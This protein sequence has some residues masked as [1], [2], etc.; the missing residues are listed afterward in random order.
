M[1]KKIIDFYND[2][3]G[4]IV[5][6]L[7]K[8]F[9]SGIKNEEELVLAS[10]RSISVFGRNKEELVVCL[11]LDGHY[12]VLSKG[13]GVNE[14]AEFALNEMGT[15]SI[16][17]NPYRGYR[18]SLVDFAK[19]IRRVLHYGRIDISVKKMHEMEKKNR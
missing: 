10:T 5:K 2:M 16:M 18:G 9:Y 4:K 19:A 12:Y 13:A 14:L 6:D 7:I 8:E 1:N 3:D 11:Y 15:D 17:L